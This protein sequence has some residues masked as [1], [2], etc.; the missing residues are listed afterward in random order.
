MVNSY[1][2]VGMP[3]ILQNTGPGTP[4][5]FAQDDSN[6]PRTR[7]MVWRVPEGV[8]GPV[9]DVGVGHVRAPYAGA[10]DAATNVEYQHNRLS[11]TSEPV[12]SV[13]PPLVYS[14]S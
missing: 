5:S 6:Q 11:E 7:R 3:S 13:S 10:Y 4:S 2:W 9:G 8:D 14:I 12:V 1:G